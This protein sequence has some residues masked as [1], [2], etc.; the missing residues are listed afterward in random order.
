MD[1]RS[2]WDNDRILAAYEIDMRIPRYALAKPKLL[3]A[4]PASCSQARHVVDA[5]AL[6]ATTN[7][8]LK[9]VSGAVDVV[10]S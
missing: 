4:W 10:S 7:R 2:G 8:R 1:G 6:G 5:A 3:R 9:D